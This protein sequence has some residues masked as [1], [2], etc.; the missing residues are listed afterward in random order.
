M[1]QVAKNFFEKER[2]VLL[3]LL[4]PIILI[5]IKSLGFGFTSMDEQW[6]IVKDTA[7]LSKWSNLKNVF[8]ES[9]GDM[10]YRPVLMVTLILDYH[11]AKLNTW[12]Y[13]LVNLLWHL[14]AVVLLYK[15]LLRIKVTRKTAFVFALLFGIHPL[16]VHAVV[17]VPGRNDILLA[18][19]TL[20]SLISLHDFIDKNQ[21][22]FLILHLLFFVL[23]LFTK[24]NAVVLPLVYAV[25][26]WS[27]AKPELKKIYPVVLSWI[28]LTLC[29][30]FL[31]NAIV[32]TSPASSNDLTTQLLNFAG[33]FLVYIG[34]TIYPFQQSVVPTIKHSSLIPGILTLL[35]FI[36]L[37]IKLGFRD[38]KLAFFGAS[39][40]FILLALPVWFGA[41]RSNGE[42]LEQRIYISMAG[43][44]IFLAQLKFDPNGK[45]FEYASAALLLVLLLKTGSRQNVYKDELSFIDAGIKETPDYY[46]FY[47]QKADKLNDLN[48]CEEAIPYYNQALALRPNYYRGISNRGSA[49]F[50]L[51]R[52][53]EAIA[54]FSNAIEHSAFDKTYHFNRCLAYARLNDMEHAMKDM[55]VLKKC[56][57]QVLDQ[58]IELEIT[59]KWSR[60]LE[61]LIKQAETDTKNAAL[62]F[63]IANLYFD[64]EMT[65]PGLTYL[66]Q[67]CLLAPENAEYK[68]LMDRMKKLNK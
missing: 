6:M 38:K 52:Y 4:L 26:Y 51:G 43:L 20:A 8:V 32:R 53:K 58:D 36:F 50:R 25:F 37:S 34:K 55:I 68:T 56:C 59:D 1:K 15:L 17:W 19:F 21:I 12:F 57:G 49:Y 60:S 28:V 64:V 54:D 2:Q 48:R 27:L 65:Q 66:K 47:F 3:V 67:A 16:L 45:V 35:F 44:F 41:S 7:Y 18:V 40:F 5:Y 23:A 14:L 9:T 24:E 62:F 46:Y 31:R 39:L 33:G 13:H 11:L 42:H 61:A 10:Y 63:R 22:K 30:L 29:W